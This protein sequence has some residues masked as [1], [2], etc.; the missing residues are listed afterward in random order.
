MCVCVYMLRRVGIA[1]S[2]AAAGA[3]TLQRRAAESHAA[4]PAPESLAAQ[5]PPSVVRVAPL[6]DPPDVTLE[7]FALR[8]LGELPRL[9]L[10]LTGI[11]YDSVYHFGTGVYKPYAPFGQLPV[12]RDGP[13][14]ICESGAIARHL[15]RKACIDGGD[16]ADKARVDMFFE[17]AKD[18]T[19][20]KSGI[21]D[22]ASA[23]GKR[24][25]AMLATA[26]ANCGGAHFVGSSTTLADVALFHALHT[27]DEARR[28][29]TRRPPPW[30]PGQRCCPPTP[31]AGGARLARA[32]PQAQGIRQEVCRAASHRRVPAQRPARAADGQRRRQA[33]ALWAAGLQVQ[34]AAAAGHVRD[35]LVSARRVRGEPLSLLR[36]WHMP[37]MRMFLASST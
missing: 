31:P 1:A 24:L 6:D 37:T 20:K 13:L 33:A 18:L 2:V 27:F 23:D 34:G 14:L 28:R 17:L 9:I 15:A 16:A 10:E 8:G 30:A 21:H 29:R 22:P 25:A 19:S 7:Y 12:L 26:E 11:P 35:A 3:A 36:R 32:V 4:A 5:R